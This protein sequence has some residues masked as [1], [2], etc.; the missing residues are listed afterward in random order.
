MKT[1]WIIRDDSGWIGQEWPGRLNI[2][3]ATTDRSTNLV[4][5]V[6]TPVTVATL[7]VPQ[8]E[9]TLAD[10]HPDGLDLPFPRPERGS[11]AGLDSSSSDD[12]SVGP[13]ALALGRSAGVSLV[14]SGIGLV[15]SDVSSAA[16]SPASSLRDDAQQP[17][18]V[19]EFSTSDSDSSQSF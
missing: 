2:D 9:S 19:P 13:M 14:S 10:A 7:V 4:H 8:P 3:V 18:E 11:R 6:K 1:E 16:S 17:V 5:W 15:G 12:S